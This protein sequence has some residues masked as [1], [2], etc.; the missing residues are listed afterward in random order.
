MYVFAFTYNCVGS[1]MSQ[2][3]GFRKTKT[4]HLYSLGWYIKK[5]FL[6][7]KRGLKSQALLQDE[8]LFL[9]TIFL[10]AEVQRG[11]LSLS[12]SVYPQ[13]LLP[14]HCTN[15]TGLRLVLYSL[16][17]SHFYDKGFMEFNGQPRTTILHPK[18]G[19]ENLA[20]REKKIK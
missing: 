7:R 19:G 6:G 18:V 5:A 15:F 16:Y 14:P 20:T 12:L 4:K 1:W 9:K 2:S 3:N 13:N 8:P 17:C 11:S 10:E